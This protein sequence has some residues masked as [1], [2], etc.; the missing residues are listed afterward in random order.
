MFCYKGK[1][2]PF[3]EHPFVIDDLVFSSDFHIGV[4]FDKNL[5]IPIGNFNGE[6]PKGPYN[7]L[8]KPKNKNIVFKISDLEGYLKDGTIIN[9]FI[10]EE[11]IECSTCEGKGEVEWEFQIYNKDFECPVCEGVG[12][13]VIEPARISDKKGYAYDEVCLIGNSYFSLELFSKIVEVAKILKEENVILEYQD[14]P[15][16]LSI[17]S[18]KDIKMVIMPRLKDLSDLVVFRI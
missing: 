11:T 4:Y 3:F 16:S 2:R 8:V 14:T 6:K 1:D 5:T 7:T 9:L 12:T 18:I 17:F 10:D 13:I 15:D